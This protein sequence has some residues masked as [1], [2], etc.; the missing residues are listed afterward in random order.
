MA[1]NIPLPGKFGDALESGAKTGSSIMQDIVMNPYDME[2]KRA[3][4]RYHD[5]EGQ[6][7]RVLSELISKYMGGGSSGAGGA[8][9]GQSGGEDL[10]MAG[11]L[12]GLPENPM[13]KAKRE[14]ET[15]QANK[16]YDQDLDM[17][18]KITDHAYNLKN[19][20]NSI[21]HLK[22]LIAKNPNLTGPLKAVIAKF[23]LSNDKELGDFISTAGKLQTEMAQLATGSKTGIGSLNLQGRIKPS[24]WNNAE[25]NLGMLSGLE[26]DVKN[27]YQ[28]AQEHIS[29]HG[30]KLPD[31]N[32][33]MGITQKQQQGGQQQQP[34]QIPPMPPAV[35][36]EF[37][38]M[39]AS[40]PPDLASKAMNAVRNN[41]DPVQ[42]M[43]RTKELMQ[44][45]SSPMQLAQQQMRRPQQQPPQQKGVFE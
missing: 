34:S 14:R 39:L 29:K 17:T 7:S 28:T 45:Q 38:A 24:E 41:K 5:A 13:S 18:G 15:Y 27:N 37:Q 40:I 31:Y 36:K 4:A 3:Q 2:A 26:E 22:D 23:K 42:V 11:W 25:F 1:L 21:A 32:E 44:K 43:A 16:K 6:K 19:T 20:Q 35:Q 12:A 10:D 8:G 30:Q 33:F 9:G